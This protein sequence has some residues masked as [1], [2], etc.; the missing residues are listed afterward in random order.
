MNRSMFQLP[1]VA[2]TFLLRMMPFADVATPDLSLMR[3]L[4]LSL[5]QVSFGMVAALLFGTLNRVMIVELKVPASFV[6]LAVAAPLVFAPFRALIGHRSDN[7]KSAF[8]WRR[9]P[10]L[11]MGTMAQFCGFAFMP[12]ALLLLSDATSSLQ[13]IV[14]TVSACVAFLLV[15]AG[16]NTTQ[17]AGLALATDLAAPA[18]RPR[19]VALMYVM[20]LLG[21]MGSAAL[22]GQLLETFTNERLIQVVQGAAVAALA[23]NVAAMWK[24]EARSAGRAQS[25]APVEPFG[26]VWRRYMG[27]TRIKRFLWAVALGTAAFSMQDIVLEPYGAEVLGLSVGSTTSLTAL[28]ALGALAAFWSASESLRRGFDAPRLAGIGA[29]IGAF[30]F[31]FV[32]FS[33]P[34]QAPA[35]FRVGS[36]IVGFGSGLFA[37]STLSAAI[38]MSDPREA[39]F[40]LGVWGAVQATAAGVAMGFGGLIRDLIATL[41]AHG[42]FGAALSGPATGYIVVFHVE[43]L[44]LFLALAAIGPLAG[45]RDEAMQKSPE[46]FGVPEFPR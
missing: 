14:G 41:T 34:F 37:V 6:A 18:S 32:I 46:S 39:G 42:L 2:R 26:A 40:A 38:S 24:Q 8:G 33:A 10:Y 4:R 15:G 43:V 30:A 12:F 20:M 44:L 35:L 23:L 13:T 25:S 3:M 22:F 29:L 27:N 17:T 28:M 11:W 1:P 45:H 36:V 5:F 9:V 19:V 31:A 16:M 7:H 21:M